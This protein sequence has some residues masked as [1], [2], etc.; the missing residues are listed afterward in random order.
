M[1]QLRDS[2]ESL[3]TIALANGFADQSHFSNLFRRHT[4][5]TPSAFRRAMQP[6]WR[7]R[8]SPPGGPTAPRADP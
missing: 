7:R 8:P 6:A 2:Q 3:A 1:E 4:G 5:V